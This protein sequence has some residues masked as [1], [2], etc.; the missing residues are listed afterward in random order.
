[1]LH[2][3]LLNSISADV[4]CFYMTLV[5]C[6]IDCTINFAIKCSRKL[7]TD[8]E[9]NRIV[10]LTEWKSEKFTDLAQICVHVF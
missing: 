9:E 2:H 4:S 5:V 10:I 7:K 6:K 1:M 8:C 3:V